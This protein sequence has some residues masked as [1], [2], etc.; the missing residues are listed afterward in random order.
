MKYAKD[1]K[2]KCGKQAEVFFGAADPDAEAPIPLC[3]KCC[4]LAKMRIYD[5]VLKIKGK[6]MKSI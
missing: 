3:E 1:F 5:A 2:C 6:N 4:T